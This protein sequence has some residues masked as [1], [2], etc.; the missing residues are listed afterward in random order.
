M[1]KITILF[2]GAHLS[3]SPTVIGLYDLLSEHF[4]VTIVAK[5]PASF[6]RQPLADRNVVYIN[7][8][9]SRVGQELKKKTFQI[10]SIF[11]KDA[12]LFA[13]IKAPY[14]AFY[15][16]KFLKKYL[17]AERPDMI[18]AVDFKNLFFAQI[19]DKRA[20]FV[21][22]EII[23]N[24]PFYNSCNFENINSVVIQTEM[25]YEYL[26][27]DKTFKT[28]YIQNAPI[29]SPAISGQERRDLVYCGTAWNPFGFY[30]CLEFIKQFSEF[31]LHV[32]GALLPTDR[33]RVLREYGELLCSGRLVIDDDY[34]DEKEVVDYLR[35]FRIGF[36]FYNFGVDWIDNFNYYSAPSGKM[37]KYFA[38]GVPVVALDTIGA[39]P[40]TEF[41]CGVLI[42]D[43]KPESIKCSIDKIESDF[44][45]YS[46]NC[47]KAAEHYSFDKTAKPFVDYLVSAA[48]K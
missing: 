38:A 7:L 20:D 33:K 32:R 23:P 27:G 17:A 35:N 37:F 13:E 41:D 3:Y 8:P 29:Y 6:D 25:R 46:E 22:L 11:D 26:F 36:S 44:D 40:I 12:K 2:S 5:S 9:V 31:S 15:E 48:Q 24:D 47:L 43:L 45:R 19:L 42:K 18:I 16:F 30:H 1:K 14:D 34:L 21:S 10:T 28:F 39:K 4:D